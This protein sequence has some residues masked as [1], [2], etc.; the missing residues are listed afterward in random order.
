[1]N[2]LDIAV[3]AIVVLSALFALARGFVR[4]ALSIIAWVGAAAITLYQY[5]Y[6]LGFTERFIKTKLLAQ[7]VAG[8]ALFLGS[9][10]ILTIITG[11]IARRVRMS[12]LSPLDRTLGLIF[13]LARGVAVVSLAYL[14][15]DVAV[16][17]SERPSWIT[18]AKSAPFL[19]QGAQMLRDL[20]PASLKVKTA[21]AASAAQR[22]IEQAGSAQRAM[23]A[24]AKP[25]GPA[26][27]PTNQAPIY[28]PGEQ[29][30]LNRVIQNNSR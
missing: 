7:F 16:P 17:Q 13:G 23:G 21:A 11:L 5:D 2:G 30:Q 27:T 25:S 15:L 28:K 10:V 20:L 18:Q 9:L 24:L 6:A 14:A 22:A 19:E 8:S 1:M 3:F 4:E 29:R 12:A 26:Q